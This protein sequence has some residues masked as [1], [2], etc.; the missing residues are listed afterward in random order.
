[1][2]K[3]LGHINK[4]LEAAQEAD[5]SLK[6]QGLHAKNS[7]AEEKKKEA[8]AKKMRALTAQIQNDFKKVTGFGNKAGY[9][10]C[11]V[12]ASI[13]VFVHMCEQAGEGEGGRQGEK[14]RQS[15]RERESE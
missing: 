4:A 7:A 12:R 8:I 15:Q 3:G 1:M 6:S 13:C 2:R 9:V 5:D 10:L 14:E 11:P